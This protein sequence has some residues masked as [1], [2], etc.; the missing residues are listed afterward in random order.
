MKLTLCPKCN[1]IFNTTNLNDSNCCPLLGCNADLIEVD[2]AMLPI[3]QEL[4]RK[5][6]RIEH[7]SSEYVDD[8]IKSYII[9][10]A[11][12]IDREFPFMVPDTI[13]L[14]FDINESSY[15]I[16]DGSL[17]SSEYFKGITIQ[18]KIDFDINIKT[19]MYGAMQE[20]I[21]ALSALHNWIKT[22]DPVPSDFYDYI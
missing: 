13:K 11:I 22:L 20:N 16:I 21:S 2:E 3:A 8:I 12:P 4:I 17:A 6:I 19:D 10:T 14:L 9:F 7:C 1:Q 15:P 18:K 5:G